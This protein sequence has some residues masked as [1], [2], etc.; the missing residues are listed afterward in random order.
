MNEGASAG[1]SRDLDLARA[2]LL[3]LTKQERSPPESIF[4][5]LSALADLW[6][7]SRNDVARAMEFLSLRGFIEGP[8]RFD[9]ESFLFRKVT[10]RGHALAQAIG[11]PRDWKAIKGQYLT[12]QPPRESPGRR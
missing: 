2:L 11:R 9:S 4:V 7:T 10:G 12:L 1:D 6:E 3:H 5:S 8:G